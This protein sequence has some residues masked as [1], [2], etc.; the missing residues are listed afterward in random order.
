VQEDEFPTVL[1]VKVYEVGALLKLGED[2]SIY[3]ALSLMETILL[4]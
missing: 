4:L 1:L 3:L 2:I